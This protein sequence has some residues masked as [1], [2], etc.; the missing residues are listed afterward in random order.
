MEKTMEREYEQEN[1]LDKF[2]RNEKRSKLWAAITLLLF[3]AASTTVIVVAN[4]MKNGGTS[5][6]NFSDTLHKTPDSSFAKLQNE[7]LLLLDSLHD[8]NVL[9]DSAKAAVTDL[10]HQLGDCKTQVT[11]T[12]TT[13][14]QPPPVVA[15][16]ISVLIHTYKVTPAAMA[17]IRALIQKSSAAN[18]G[19]NISEAPEPE[20]KATDGKALA[21]A[22]LRMPL[23]TVSLLKYYDSKNADKATA[24]AHDL[25]SNAGSFYNWQE[26][27]IIPGTGSQG[28]ADIEIW[29]RN[30]DKYYPIQ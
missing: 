20:I 23:R 5:T 11:T 18:D 12:P 13:P 9:Y 19:I 29:I 6:Q 30:V 24:I 14:T 28:G 22:R 15:Q 4:Q 26:M 1:L 21:R 17:I 3:F 16:P 2:I 25:N 27:N 7:N 10:S 8:L